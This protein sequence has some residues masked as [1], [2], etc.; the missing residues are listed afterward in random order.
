MYANVDLVLGTFPDA[1]LVPVTALITRAGRRGVFVVRDGK[2]ARFAETVL[3][4]QDGTWAQVLEGLTENDPMVVDGGAFL[5]DGSP[6]TALGT[7]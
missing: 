7:P 1:L 2:T 6:V 4:L 5:E 3:G